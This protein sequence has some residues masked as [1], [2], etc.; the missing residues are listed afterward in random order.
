MPVN[1]FQ[2]E[3]ALDDFS[4]KAKEL[5]S[6]LE[7]T[8]NELRRQLNAAASHT[9]EIR[10]RITQAEK[11][12]RTLYCAKPTHE[13]ILSV[14]D[15]PPAP[16]NYTL[17][18][19]DGSQIAPNRHRPL[20]FCVI[21]VGLIK[22]RR[23]SG[24][25]P[26]IEIHSSLLDHELL[27]GSDGR[28]IGEDTVA[29]HRDAA[30]RQALLD[31][32]G[33]DTGPVFT[34]TDGPLDVYQGVRGIEERHELLSRLNEIYT[35]MAARG[36]VNAGYIDK[37]GSELLSRMLALLQVPPA[38]LSMWSDQRR[39]LRGISDARLLTQLLQQPGQ[40]SAIF[41]AVARNELNK[42]P[43]PA[44]HFFY[45]NV[46]QEQPYLARVEFPAW[47]SGQPQ[48]VDWLQ[49]VV[50]QE[51]QVL[52]RHPYP[53]LLHRAHEL[54][55]ISFEEHEHVEA[56]LMQHFTQAGVPNGMPSNKDTTK[57][58]SKRRS[59]TWK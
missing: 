11:L 2:V 40:R 54:A 59:E 6:T 37:P 22:V 50:Y 3:N 58:F 7:A 28:V 56:M 15:L 38:E 39:T 9:A 47:V 25:E 13:E 8:E 23:G 34:L 26:E 4:K 27:F 14:H 29:L 45:L 43:R 55:V 57:A 18:A 48:L 20:M 51:A 19:A 42:E 52:D 35:A 53:Y 44:V 21:N 10:E 30:E 1:Y 31:F 24:L 12:L 16:E 33:T 5:N 49:A 36:V 41:E 17:A 46:S 32:T